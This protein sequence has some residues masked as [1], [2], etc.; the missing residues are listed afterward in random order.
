MCVYAEVARRHKRHVV[1]FCD[2]PGEVTPTFISGTNSNHHAP[3]LDWF[4]SSAATSYDI[5]LNDIASPNVT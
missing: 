1:N 2:I 4:A 5:D 3:L